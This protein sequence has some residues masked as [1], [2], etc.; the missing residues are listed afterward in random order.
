M[1]KNLEIKEFSIVVVAKNHNPTIL[2]PDFLKINKIVP[3]EWQ[4][5]RNPICVE[6]MSQVAFK[7]GITITAQLDRVIFLET[8][9]SNNQ[10]MTVPMI[11]RKYIEILP[12]VEYTAVGIN[13]KGHFMF[14]GEGSNR[15]YLV[16]T[17]I[18]PGPWR[19][20]GTAP[21]SAEIKFIYTLER[22]FYFLT[23]KAAEWKNPE[24]KSSPVIFF[25]ANFHHGLIGEN[26]TERLDDLLKTIEGWKKEVDLYKDHIY[27]GF[28]KPEV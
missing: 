26:R 18:T 7:N 19:E 1:D 28:L 17:L 4:L 15:E 21:A 22:E 16:K 2:N 11:A 5:A 10:D 6:P 20:F 25:D 8:V 3:A 9:Q 12:H 24:G 13:P 14:E 23:V 27:Q